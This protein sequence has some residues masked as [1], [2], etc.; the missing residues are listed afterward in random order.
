MLYQMQYNLFFFF[1]T[2]SH[3]IPVINVGWL[4]LFNVLMVL[5]LLPTLISNA[6]ILQWFTHSYSKLCAWVKISYFFF[7]LC[8]VSVFGRMLHLLLPH[9]WAV[10]VT[11]CIQLSAY[12]FLFFFIACSL[13]KMIAISHPPLLKAAPV[14]LWRVNKS[15]DPIL[16]PL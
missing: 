10:S 2:L 1:Y 8:V 4:F 11:E 7:F 3:C 15:R 6:H 5:E 12:A 9:I 16:P 14:Q 13:F